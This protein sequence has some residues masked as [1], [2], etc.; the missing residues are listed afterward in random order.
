MRTSPMRTSVDVSPLH[1]ATVGFDRLF[2]LLDRASVD[3]AQSNY[4]PYNIERLGEHA[5]RISVAVAGFAENELD[6]EVRENALTITGKKEASRTQGEYLHQGIAT[7]E[8]TRRFELADT[9]RVK[10][11]SLENGLL[12]VDLVQEVP[13]RLKPRKI[14][15]NQPVDQAQLN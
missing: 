7:R 4:P 12:N 2:D 5:Y 11:A 14:S 6:V 9:V 3:N 8:F 1:R 15:I 10:G 13:E